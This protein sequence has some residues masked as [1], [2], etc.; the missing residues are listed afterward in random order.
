MKWGGSDNRGTQKGKNVSLL[1][2]LGAIKHTGLLLSVIRNIVL[3][4]DLMSSVVQVLPAGELSFLLFCMKNMHDVI[5]MFKSE[6]LSNSRVI[7]LCVNNI[8]STYFKCGRIRK[9]QLNVC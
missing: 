5:I 4:N 9:G 8:N 6:S 3:L 1:C 7:P 2:R